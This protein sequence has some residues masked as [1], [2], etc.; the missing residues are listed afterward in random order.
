MMAQRLRFDVIAHNAANAE[1]T[2]TEDGT[3]FRRQI[4]VFAEDLPYKNIDTRKFALGKVV[5]TPEFNRILGLKLD[6]RRERRVAGV[7]VIE[8]VEDETPLTP[9]Y[10]PSHPDAN[11][12]GYYYLPNVDIAEEQIDALAATRSHESNYAIYDAMLNMTKKALTI[13]K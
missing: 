13:G 2:R 8:I 1:T 9:V 3:P 11:E 7:K 4:S 6:E 10:D 12:E 5:G